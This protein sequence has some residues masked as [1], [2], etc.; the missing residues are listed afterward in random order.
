M[1]TKIEANFKSIAGVNEDL[2][3]FPILTSLPITQRH[4]EKKLFGEVFTPPHLIDRMIEI[5]KPLPTQQNCDL[6]AGRGN[7]TVR[8]LRYFTNSFPDFNLPHYL[9][10]N[11]YF[12]EFNPE[13][14]KDIIA[15]FGTEI[16]LFLGPAQ[17]LKHL[18]DNTKGFWQHNGKTW[19]ETTFTQITNLEAPK[20]LVNDFFD[21]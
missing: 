7:F 8:M 17:E 12:N 19:I 4:T 21:F 1:L 14:A 5:S 18:P 6:C 9:K 20:E 3:I 15:I 16:N 10:H 2:T 13:N 11:H